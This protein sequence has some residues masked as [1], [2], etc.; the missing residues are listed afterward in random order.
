MFLMPTSPKKKGKTGRPPVRSGRTT[1]GRS[2]AI[3]HCRIDQQIAA[4]LE[5]WLTNYNASHPRTTKGAVVEEALKTFLKMREAE[6]A[7]DAE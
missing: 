7:S 4:A 3:L 6:A 5:V 2:G 1:D